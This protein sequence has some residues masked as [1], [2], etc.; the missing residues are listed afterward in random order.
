PTRTD[1]GDT[2]WDGIATDITH[3]KRAELQLQLANDE[4]ARATRMKDEFLANMS[5]ELRT[6]LSA[7]LGMNE[8]M[9]Q[10]LFGPVTPKQKDG[11]EVIE[12]SA[13]H[14]LELIDE[15][16]DLAKIEAGSTELEFQTI[17]MR[18][19]LELSL[20][21]VGQQ[22][23]KKSIQLNLNVPGDMPEIEAD[24]KRL[25]Q[26]LINLLSNAVKF[27]P[28]NGQVTLDVKRLERNA[29]RREEMVR[30]SVTDTGIGIHESEFESLFEPFIQ[31]DSALNRNYE[32]SGLGLAL[33]KQFVELHSGHVNVTSEPGVG[34][35]FSVEIPIRQPGTRIA[36]SLEVGQESASN[37]GNPSESS[38]FVLLAEDNQL[39]ANATKSFLEASNF[40][41]QLVTDGQAAID[42][43]Q[44]QRPDVILMDV[45]MPGVDGLEAIRRLRKIPHLAETPII[46]LTGLAMPGDSKRCLAAGANLY[47]SKPYGMQKLVNTIRDLL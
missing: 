33:V 35:C 34:S 26:V 24:E 40:Q 32:G 13:S 17:D 11:Y 43:A 44:E 47:L 23:R 39:V 28:D 2:I 9:Q 10:G 12:Q 36:E 3:R 42:A 31:V 46:A 15:I 7:I 1:T 8:G 27:T 19:I 5:H 41:L 18:E 16:L 37:A 29:E 6:P 30:I 21:L 38:A 25:R 4:L 20:R 22:A 45:Q 14:L